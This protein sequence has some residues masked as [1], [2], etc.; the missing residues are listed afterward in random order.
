MIFQRI[1][2]GHRKLDPV[3]RPDI[4][5]RPEKCHRRKWI[6]SFD[7]LVGA[8]EHR[9]IEARQANPIHQKTETMTFNYFCFA[10]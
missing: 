1:I 8:G 9:A 10:G 7:H 2:A 4:A 5:L 6:C 3:R